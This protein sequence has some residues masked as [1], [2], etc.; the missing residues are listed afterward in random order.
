MK[1]S[2]RKT[3]ITTT[4]ATLSLV[5]IG[6]IAVVAYLQLGLSQAQLKG[7]EKLITESL[8]SKGKIL[9]SSHALALKGFV[10]A[11]AMSDVRDLVTRAVE[12]DRSVIYGLFL[13]AD[14][15]PW[16]YQAPN[17]DQGADAWNALGIDDDFL[18]GES[19]YRKLKLFEQEIWEFSQKVELEDEIV[20]TIRY[21]LSTEP[22]KLELDRAR[23]ESEAALRQTLLILVVLGGGMLLLGTFITLRQATRITSPLG[24]L[25]DAAKSI[26][27]GEQA[28]HV[29]VR[30]G[31]ELEVLA[32]SFNQMV[33]DLAASYE[34][35][36]SLNRDLEH[37]V[38]DRTRDLRQKTV[39]VENM[40]KNLQQGILTI[41][42]GQTVHHEYSAYLEKI[43]ERKEIAGKGL[44]D[45]LLKSTNLGVDAVDRINVALSN[46]LGKPSINFILN[47]H[48]LPS[49]FEKQFPDERKKILEVEWN[50]IADDSGQTERMMLTLRDV[51]ELRSLQKA[52]GEQQRQLEI[53]GQVL[54]VGGSDFEGFMRSSFDFVDRNRL[55]LESENVD[56]AALG[57]LFRNMHTIKGNA[58]TY[59]LN[60]LNDILHEAETAYKKFRDDEEDKPT[61]EELLVDLDGVTAALTEYQEV[62]ESKLKGASSSGG[63][64]FSEELLNACRALTL[65][66]NEGD[67]LSLNIRERLV[68]LRKL[69]DEKSVDD[70]LRGPIQ[71]AIELATELGKEPPVFEVSDPSIRVPSKTS[72]LLQNVLVHV[73]RNAVDHGLEMPEERSEKGKDPC[74]RITVTTA[75]DDATLRITVG[76]DG[77]GLNLGSLRDKYDE[78]HGAGSAEKASV[79]DLANIIFESGL[80]TAS[81]VTDVSGRGVGM[82]AVRSFVK[83]EGGSVSLSLIGEPSAERPCPFEVSLEIP[84]SY[85]TS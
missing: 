46:M 52:M 74:G 54:A 14:L 43:L 40:L 73:F 71:G 24:V 42:S 20:G 2:L 44:P 80:S 5:S 81:E 76:D 84:L 78:L 36:E 59:Q 9:S 49:E 37:K 8:E 23:S 55:I 82:D 38:E 83:A 32:N 75:S 70:V 13:D 34:D 72:E 18:E 45:V 61:H 56:E 66:L 22:M 64:E 11:M 31:D 26:S 63:G 57:E 1:T 48:L 16:A 6:M 47:S 21:G 4:A 10:D 60:F 65:L 69:V 17:T 39:D 25:T 19:G 51:T 28:V 12:E 15:N 3:L 30:S 50:A 58:R 68:A 79:Q 29:D 77:R 7:D 67:S 35:L 41:T 53:V 33:S 62:F 85:S 27:S